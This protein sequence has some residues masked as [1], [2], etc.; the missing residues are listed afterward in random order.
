MESSD[1]T[2]EQLEQQ[3]L[4]QILKARGT[5]MRVAKQR[6]GARGATAEE[7]KLFD[8]ELGAPVLT[9]SRIVYDDGGH[10]VEYGSSSSSVS[11][12]DLLVRD[13]TLP[14]TSS[15]HAV[16]RIR[17]LG[18]DVD[19]AVRGSSHLVVTAFARV[20]NRT[21]SSPY[22]FVSPKSESFIRRS[23]VADGHQSAR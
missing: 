12:R 3:G 20:K 6:I 8:R 19:F 17:G 14:S 10:A 2:A 7:A 9:M 21:L 18:I 5:S 16:D 23:E 4:Y 13:H 11:P 22:A 15:Q 1:I